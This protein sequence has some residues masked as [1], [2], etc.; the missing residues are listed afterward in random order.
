MK[1]I[2]FLSILL[3]MGGL[4]HGAEAKKDMSEAREACRGDLDKFCAG[5]QSGSGR[6][7]RC[8]KEHANE[9]TPQCKLQL[10]NLHGNRH[11]R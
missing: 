5:V 6:K 1:K 2:F 7:I 8:L 9:L 10:A 11:H 4:A 3:S